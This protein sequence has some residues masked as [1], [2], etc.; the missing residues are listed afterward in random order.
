MK[1]LWSSNYFFPEV[2]SALGEPTVV[3]GGWMLALAQDV[4]AAGQ[5]LAVAALYKGRTVRKIQGEKITYYLL[6][7]LVKSRYLYDRA[8]L[9]HWKAVLEDF[10]PD[11]VHIHG[12]EY[13]YGLPLAQA[14]KGKSIPTVVSIQGM[15]SVYERHY[16]AGIPPLAAAFT[17]TLLDNLR[18]TGMLEGRNRFRVRSKYEWALLRQVRHVMGRTLWDYA[19]TR[20]INPDMVYHL[21]QE[22]LRDP[23][24]AGG[25]SLSTMERHTIF[26]SQATYPVKGLHI[27]LEALHILR[28]DIPDVR[29]MVAG[30]DVTGGSG[31]KSRL[32]RTGY[33]KYLSRLIGRY[34]LRDCVTFTGSLGAEQMAARMARA[35]V[36]TLNSSIENSPNSLGE[37][38]LMGTPCVA[39]YVGG[40]PD[41]VTDGVDG[42][43][44]NYQE[45][46]ILAERLR[47]LMSDDALAERLSQGGRASACKRH[48]RQRNLQAVLD[49]Y[50]RVRSQP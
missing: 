2:S 40:V 8:L 13:A 25:W 45:P 9:T 6:P 21:C 26:C 41:M 37:A 14:A 44:Y 32:R 28:R 29:L 27:L 4:V 3:H 7:G 31:W 18:F 49:T 30:P 50:E 38:Q 42:L 39:A 36:F 46:A 20:A 47:A 12:T 24:Y 22:S 35:H 23:F 34:G 48:D 33:G 43:L 16:L 10:V 1:I 19:N 11:V 5:T 15:I 17:R